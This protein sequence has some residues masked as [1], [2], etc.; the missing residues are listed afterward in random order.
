[1]DLKLRD[2]PHIDAMVIETNL[3]SWAVTRIL[4]DI[5]SSTDILFASTF[6]NIRLDKTFSN[7]QD[8]HYMDLVARK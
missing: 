7:Q 6:D 4:V 1:M 3:A 5:G 2:Y 8:T